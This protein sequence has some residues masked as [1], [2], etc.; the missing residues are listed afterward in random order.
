MKGSQ[1]EQPRALLGNISQYDPKRTRT[2]AILSA[3]NNV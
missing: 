2:K 3:Y 1:D